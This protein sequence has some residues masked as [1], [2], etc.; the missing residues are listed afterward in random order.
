MHTYTSG[1]NMFLIFKHGVGLITGGFTADWK[2]S[3]AEKET[4]L[5]KFRS[6]K[7]GFHLSHNKKSRQTLRELKGDLS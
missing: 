4:G 3:N 1:S 5:S 6:L 2:F 7:S